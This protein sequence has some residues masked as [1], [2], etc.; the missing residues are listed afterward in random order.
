MRYMSA[1]GTEFIVPNNNNHTVTGLAVVVNEAAFLTIIK[2][3][4]APLV[5][6][7]EGGMLK[8]TYKYLTSY[9]GIG[10]VCSSSNRLELPSDAEVVKTDFLNI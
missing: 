6:F 7:A 2:R 1:F 9:K 8:T 3:M 5:V 4:T 10:F